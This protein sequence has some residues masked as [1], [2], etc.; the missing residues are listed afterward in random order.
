MIVQCPHCGGNVPVSGLGRR[1]LNIPLKN[2][3]ETLQKHHSVAATAEELACSEGYI[4]KLLKDNGL[5]LKKIYSN[6]I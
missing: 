1:R 4:Y 5:N 3:L 2:I 6:A